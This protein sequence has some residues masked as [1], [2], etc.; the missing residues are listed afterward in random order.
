MRCTCVYW[1]FS[2]FQQV[3][4]FPGG[5]NRLG[6]FSLVYWG[7]PPF[8]KCFTSLKA[9]TG[10]VDFPGSPAVYRLPALVLLVLPVLPLPVF[11]ARFDRCQVLSVGWRFYGGSWLDRGR[12]WLLPLFPLFTAAA[13]TVI[14]TLLFQSSMS[15]QS[16]SVQR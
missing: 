2:T 5:L 8:R 13:T 15:G 7:F 3:F 14:A 6:G 1:G 4:H 10:L 11:P 12:V 9:L 16:A